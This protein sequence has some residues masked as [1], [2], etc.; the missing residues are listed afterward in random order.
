MLIP[1]NRTIVITRFRENISWIFGLNPKPARI[2]VYNKGP[3]LPKFPQYVTIENLENVGNGS[4]SCLYHAFKYHKQLHKQGLIVFLQGDPHC[5]NWNIVQDINLLSG[6]EQFKNLGRTW[7][8][9]KPGKF[10]ED[11]WEQLCPYSTRSIPELLRAPIGDLFCVQGRR[12]QKRSTR[13][14]QRAMDLCVQD[15]PF[16][17]LIGKSRPLTFSGFHELV[18]PWIYGGY[19]YHE[20]K[21]LLDQ[22]GRDPGFLDPRCKLIRYL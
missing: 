9:I 11:L 14:Y 15:P 3:N 13:F 19:N 6:R 10:Y 8:K 18:L 22:L 21:E 7:M 2:F 20:Y 1:V 16:V 5:H 4:H 12:V 17:D